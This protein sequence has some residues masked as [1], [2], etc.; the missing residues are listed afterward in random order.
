MALVGAVISICVGLF[1]FLCC[2]RWRSLYICLGPLAE[3]F[4]SSQGHFLLMQSVSPGAIKNPKNY[5][6]WHTGQ[7]ETQ[8]SGVS[9]L[10]T[11]RQIHFLLDRP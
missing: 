4:T 6:V 7:K 8:R 9:V 5:P 3:T 10:V 11:K 1:L 2:C